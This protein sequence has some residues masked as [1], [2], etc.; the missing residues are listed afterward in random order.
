MS[1]LNSENIY[2]S[3]YNNIQSSNVLI[4]EKQ[5]ILYD[6]LIHK[7]LYKGYDRLTDPLHI[8]NTYISAI[9]EKCVI[10]LNEAIENSLDQIESII[11]NRKIWL[12]LSGGIDSTLVFYALKKRGFSFTVASCS[13]AIME[14]PKLF[15]RLLNFDFPNINFCKMTSMFFNNISK[16]KD[17]LFVTGEIGDQTIGSMVTMNLPY[18]VRTMYLK[19]GINNDILR[20]YLI[21]GIE[22]NGNYTKDAIEEYHNSI[23]WL[24]KDETNCTFAEFLWSLNFIYKYLLVIYRLYGIGLIQYGPNK[25]VYHFYDTIKFQQYAMSHYEINCAYRKPY[26]YKQSFKD[27]IYTQ[28]G[29]DEY[30]KYKLKVPSLK[31]T[32]YWMLYKRMENILNG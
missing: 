3:I 4:T 15:Y 29:D 7:N 11:G 1:I 13:D 22:Y 19:Q 5:N 21:P 17:I 24:G 10:E 18:E 12:L 8:G 6:S 23:S 9:P 32:D 30:R 27:W 20:N 16:L 31:M 28:N 25:N 26:E 2:E 14:Y